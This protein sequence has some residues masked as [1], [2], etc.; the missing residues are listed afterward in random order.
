MSPY[1]TDG[2]ATARTLSTGQYR[3]DYQG[4]GENVEEDGRPISTGSNGGQA[5]LTGKYN[6]GLSLNID[7]KNQRGRVR[8]PNVKV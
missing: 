6:A 7:R 4:L 5:T 8:H 2:T 1:V 3:V